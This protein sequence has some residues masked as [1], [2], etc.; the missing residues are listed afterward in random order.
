M[1]ARAAWSERLG[2]EDRA[3]QRQAC[4]AACRELETQPALRT[5][6]RDLL[7]RGS[8]RARF[9]A[10]WVLVRCD[11]PSLR[12]LPALLD[13]LELPDG[14]LRWSAA[15]MLTALGRTQPEVFAVLL[16][17]A[18]D[19]SRPAARRRMLLYALRELGPDRPETGELLL[20]AL[21]DPAPDVR[22][23]ALSSFG[24][25]LE[26]DRACLERALEI[27][28]ADPDPK[29][30]RIAATLLPDLVQH[31][32]DLA[33]SAAER[34]EQL[35]GADDPLLAQAARTAALRLTPGD[36]APRGDRNQRF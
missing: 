4:D 27:A 30:R 19:A 7:R 9:A 2:S 32:P 34:L 17:E 33:E 26:P 31:H 8:P 14:D 3:I 10:A 20:A 28:A 5:E 18:R 16:G 35:A 11:P 6:L 12:V 23:A 36:R 21:A 22:R 25:L 29:L 13:A 24:K 1:S 15:H